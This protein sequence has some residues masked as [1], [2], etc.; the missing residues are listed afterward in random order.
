MTTPNLNLKTRDL[1][2][3]LVVVPMVAVI[4]FITCY[5]NKNKMDYSHMYKVDSKYLSRTL[6]VW[7]YV[8]F[9]QQ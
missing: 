1:Y 2:D 5:K 9:G 4:N 7:K 6:E 8:P 3:P